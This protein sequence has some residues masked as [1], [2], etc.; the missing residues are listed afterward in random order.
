MDNDYVLTARIVHVAPHRF[1]VLVSALVAPGQS[2][3]RV[4][5][6]LMNELAESR[7]AALALRDQMLRALGKKLVDRGDRVID[8]QEEG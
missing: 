1:Q 4:A 7:E 8:V 6:V 3:E 2:L 5:P